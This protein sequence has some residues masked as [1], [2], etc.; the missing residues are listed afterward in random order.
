MVVSSSAAAAM[1]RL[2]DAAADVDA[3]TIADV[4]AVAEDGTLQNRIQI[5]KS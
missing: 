4:P 2:V 3:T 1:P 5:V